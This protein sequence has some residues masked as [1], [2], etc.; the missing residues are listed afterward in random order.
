MSNLPPPPTST[1]TP[2]DGLDGRAKRS[3]WTASGPGTRVV[4]TVLRQYSH[5]TGYAADWAIQSQFFYYGKPIAN[6]THHRRFEF[7]DGSWVDIQSHVP[8]GSYSTDSK[9]VRAVVVFTGTASAVLLGPAFGLA[10]LLVLAFTTQLAFPYDAAWQGYTLRYYAPSNPATPSQPWGTQY[11]YGWTTS[12]HPF[13][14]IRMNGNTDIA[15]FPDFADEPVGVSWWTW[16]FPVG[17][18]P[19]PAEEVTVVHSR[20]PRAL[21]AAAQ[22]SADQLVQAMPQLGQATTE[23]RMPEAWDPSAPAPLAL[24]PA[25]LAVP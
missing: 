23:K 3:T 12:F 10:E 9:A 25:L 4:P 18:A 16:R 20:K 13:D 11:M 1:S 7:D 6:D 19:R 17:A 22:H 14:P 21:E 8:V 24:A 5:E 15:E 2:L